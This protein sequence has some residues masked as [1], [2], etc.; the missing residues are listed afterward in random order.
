M[1]LPTAAAFGLSDPLAVLVFLSAIARSLV[2]GLRVDFGAPAAPKSATY[3][4]S[5]VSLDL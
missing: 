4:N 3:C 1:Q 2:E 5:S